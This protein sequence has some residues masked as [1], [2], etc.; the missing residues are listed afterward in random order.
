M[1]IIIKKQLFLYLIILFF[2]SIFHLDIKSSVGNDSTISEWF[3][4]Y[5]GGFTK[6]GII[7][8]ISIFFSRFL[9]IFDPVESKNF[10]PLY[11]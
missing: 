6:R 7:G 2:F 1:K 5:T 8:Q 10:N 4:N 11:S 9:S 3:I